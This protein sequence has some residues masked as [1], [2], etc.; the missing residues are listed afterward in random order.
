MNAYL[1]KASKYYGR[2][3]PGWV[4]VCHGQPW[5]FFGRM[6]KKDAQAAVNQTNRA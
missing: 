6:G 2:P 5:H 3:T 1:V 4:A